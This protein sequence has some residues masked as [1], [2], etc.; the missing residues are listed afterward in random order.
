VHDQLAP[1]PY[2]GS[3]KG[4]VGAFEERAG[5]DADLSSLLVALLRAAN[6]PARYEYGTVDLTPEQAMAWTGTTEPGVAADALAS[7]ASLQ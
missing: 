7:G 2:Y 4:S 1:E 6:V 3:K 5:N